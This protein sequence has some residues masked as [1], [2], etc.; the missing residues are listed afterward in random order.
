MM[1]SKVKRFLHG[2]RRGLLGCLCL[3]TAL[4]LGSVESG[5]GSETAAASQAA[6]LIEETTERLFAEMDANGSRA[7][8]LVDRIV[9]PHVDYEGIARLVLGRH[10]SDATAE[11]RTR[12]TEEFRSLLVRSYANTVADNADAA[13]EYLPASLRSDGSEAMV[14]TRVTGGSREALRI[15]YR[16]H[17]P[18][19]EWMLVDV[20]VEG[21]SLVTTH[22]SSFSEQIG[23]EGLDGLIR[24]LAERNA[25]PGSR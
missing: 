17:R 19:G 20:V 15:D 21:I 23:K 16:L 4:F 3:G 5:H 24:A 7:I 6:Q 8:A 13:I 11:Q 12:F 10:W 14:S 9:S 25:K 1:D 18:E 22:R 2:G